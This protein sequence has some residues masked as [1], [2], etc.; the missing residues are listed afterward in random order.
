[1]I[2]ASFKSTLKGVYHPRLEY[3]AAESGDRRGTKAR[4]RRSPLSAL[5]VFSVGEEDDQPQNE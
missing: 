2:S 5:S 4:R 1:M 3:P